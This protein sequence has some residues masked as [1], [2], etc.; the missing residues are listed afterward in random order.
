MA[1]SGTKEH[2]KILEP[3]QCGET[4][5]PLAPPKDCSPDDPL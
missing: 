1:H 2:G 3:G 5:S 4:E